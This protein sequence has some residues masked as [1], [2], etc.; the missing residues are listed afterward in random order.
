[1]H[2]VTHADLA[3]GGRVAA[4]LLCSGDAVRAHVSWR[5]QNPRQLNKLRTSGAEVF[6]AT[7]PPFEAPRDA[8]DSRLWHGVSGVVHASLTTASY[9]KETVA[10]LSSVGVDALLRTAGLSAAR[11]L[12]LL[13][14]PPI[15]ETCT[16]LQQGRFRYTLLQPEPPALELFAPG[17]LWSKIAERRRQIFFLP[18]QQTA[19]V[20][21]L[22]ATAGLRGAV[23]RLPTAVRRYSSV[24]DRVETLLQDPSCHLSDSLL[25]DL[26]LGSPYKLVT[27]G[28]A[29]ALGLTFGD[30]YVTQ[31]FAEPLA[32]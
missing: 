11:Q 27:P 6:R 17:G 15:G 10:S 1:M 23:L 16:L 32:S 14:P 9:G 26:M 3:F 20:A 8:S 13:S 12:V 28:V 25:S 4:R 7:L 24:V 5:S 29:R 19:D 22:A 30:N 2:L 31:A 21:V 18:L